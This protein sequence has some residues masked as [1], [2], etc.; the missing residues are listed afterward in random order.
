[1]EVNDNGSCLKSDTILINIEPTPNINFGADTTICKSSNYMLNAGVGSSYLWHNGL[2]TQTV[3]TY[4]EGKY[5]VTVGT[6]C[7]DKDSINITFHT[8]PLV[9]YNSSFE[10]ERN[11]AAGDVVLT[12][13]MPVGGVYSGPGVTGNIFNTISAGDGIHKVDYSYT[14]ITNGCAA[15]TWVA[16]DVNP[17]VS[18]FKLQH[19]KISIY[20]NP[21][22]D[23]INL[24]FGS[25]NNI[26]NAHV[27][28]YDKQGKL[29][30]SKFIGNPNNDT[31][32][33]IESYGLSHGVYHLVISG[34]DFYK[35]IKL[36]K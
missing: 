30:A 21:F 8:N 28:L 15:T 27:N 31:I 25:S 1:M 11:S 20:P 26:E 35:D 22:N 19:G 5:V 13:G 23:Y 33:L 16:M 3:P 17:T 32:Y 7:T 34:Q 9:W 4:T 36:V 12:F 14:E 6:N 24:E 10:T 29:V 2:T 18:T